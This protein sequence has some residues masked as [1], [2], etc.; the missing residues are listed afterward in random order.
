MLERVDAQESLLK[1]HSLNVIIEDIFV[2]TYL[3]MKFVKIKDT[4]VQNILKLLK[5]QFRMLRLDLTTMHTI[6]FNINID[7]KEVVSSF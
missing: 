7:L 2:S 5:K 1:L 4:Q 3:I 6:D